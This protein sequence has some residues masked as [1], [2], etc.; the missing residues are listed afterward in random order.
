MIFTHAYFWRTVWSLFAT[1]FRLWS[2]CW[3]TATP[4]SLRQRLTQ[5]YTR[6]TSCFSFFSFLFFLSFFSCFFFLSFFSF[7]Y[8]PSSI[9]NLP[10]ISHFTDNLCTCAGPRTGTYG[11][12]CILIVRASGW[13]RSRRLQC[14]QKNSRLRSILN[15]VLLVEPVLILSYLTDSKKGTS[16]S[17]LIR[18]SPIIIIL[19]FTWNRHS[20]S[21]LLLNSA[22]A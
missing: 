8:L 17:L 21:P 4:S 18:S 12:W 10:P 22:A 7:L 6:F 1:A 20:R 19:I 16:R 5:T 15:F 3:T 9:F 13:Y 14:V 2:Y 11:G